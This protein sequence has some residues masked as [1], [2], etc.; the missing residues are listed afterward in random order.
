MINKLKEN[1][2]IIL[3]EN[4]LEQKIQQAEKENRKLIIKLGFDPTAPDLH[5]GHAVVL[6]KLKEF[7]NLGH[8][9]IIVVGSLTARIGDP[10]GKN[11]ARKPLSIEDVQ[12]NAETYISQLSKVIDVEKTKIVF[13]SDWLD[14][15]HFSQVIQLMSKVT[16]AQLMH[17]NDF[18]KRFT[19]NTPIAMH[20]LVY[21]ILQGFDSVKIE[22]DIEIG[23]TDQLFNCTMGRQLQENH[24]ISP[25]IVMCMPLLKGLDGKEKMSKSLNNI[26][27]LADEPNEMFGK[28]MSIPDSLIEE[29]LN[30]TTNFSDEEK[31]N[32]KLKIKE[33]ENPMNIKKMIA[34]NI[35]TQY[36]NAESAENAER[37]FMNQFQNKNFDEKVFEPIFINSLNHIQHKIIL[38]E[39]CHQLKN[40]ESKSFIRKLIENGGIQINNIKM[41]DPNTEIELLKGTKIKIGKRSFFELL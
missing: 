26:I 33:N 10:T 13:N 21:P 5:L 34:K 17:R 15:L 6:K 41:T 28:T 1:V 16:V 39:L 31:G 8:Q 40:S 24:G 20:E 35:I 29:F 19:E 37:F 9:I 2:E 3:P 4:G 36:H 22:C 23:G 30:L 12:H 27:G 11:K 32:I 18:N 14:S 38:T 25:Q 7:Q